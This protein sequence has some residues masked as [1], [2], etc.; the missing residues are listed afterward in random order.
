MAQAVSQQIARAY[1]P[2]RYHYWYSLGKLAMDPL[3]GV[4]CA[5]LSNNTAPLLDVGCGIGILLH[6]LRA[7][8]HA[9]RYIGV[10]NDAEKLALARRSAARNALAHAEFRY[11]D[12]TCEFPAHRGSV[13]LLDVLQYL[14]PADQNSLLANAARSLTTDGLLV[15]RSGLDDGG[16]RARLTRGADR[17]G[18]SMGWIKADFRAQPKPAALAA[19]LAGL[20]LTADFHPAWGRTPFNNWLVVARRT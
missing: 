10:D 8:G 14:E 9:A 15:M 6:R 11:C 4:V 18:H 20:G 5:A 3:Y 7:D 2:S 17:F 19:T 13:A 12:L 16:W 1:L